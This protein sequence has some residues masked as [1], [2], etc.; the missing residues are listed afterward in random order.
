M[1]FGATN[2][3]VALNG[4]TAQFNF[5]I[6]TNGLGSFMFKV[7]DARAFSYT[8]TVN[9]HVVIPTT[10][11]A[12]VLSAVSSRNINVGVNLNI[13]NTATDADVPAQILTFGLPIGPT[14]ATLGASSG[15]FNWR[16]LVTQANTTNPV[17]I[18][19]TDNGAP[20]LERDSKFQHNGQSTDTTD[21]RRA[22]V[23]HRANWI[24]CERPGRAGLRRAILDQPCRIG[25]RSSSPIR[26]RCRSPGLTPNMGASSMQFLPHQDRSAAALIQK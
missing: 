20:N 17:T 22:V 23:D 4:K 6:N 16:P 12:P 10:N 14:N 25:T 5:T 13:T 19:V 15:V 3:T 24:F 18:V 1:C 21:C 8:N 7:T 9:V 26:R 2:G 11:T